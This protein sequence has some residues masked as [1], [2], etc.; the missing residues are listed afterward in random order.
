MEVVIAGRPNAG[1]SSLLNA[2][3]GRDSAIVTEI[4]GTTRDILREH[5][6]ID[7]MPL[8]LIDT[9]GLR[10]SQDLVEQEGI[11]RAWAE[12]EKADRILLVVDG[13]STKERNPE[14]LWPEFTKEL[15]DK[16]NI[17][18]VVNKLDLLHDAELSEVQ[19]DNCPI[20]YLSAKKGTGVQELKDHLKELMGYSLSGEGGFIARQRHLTALKR[21]STSLL[22]GIEQ[23]TLYNAGEL[24][25]EEL[26]YTQEAM[27]EITGEFRSDDLLGEIFS[28]FCIGK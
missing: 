18:L 16:K 24:L 19:T 13:S 7:G 11:R 6:H 1:K 12:I 22:K 17:T 9:A 27:S 20:I 8:H 3:A 14:K 2:L 23:L 28:S 15:P 25:A 4:A 26:R 5:I 21:A 10:K